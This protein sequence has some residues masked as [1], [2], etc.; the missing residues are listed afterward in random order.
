MAFVFTLCSIFAPLCSMNS[1]SSLAI[2]VNVP[3]RFTL[4]PQEEGETFPITKLL[5]FSVEN[6]LKTEE[7]KNIQEFLLSQQW[8]VI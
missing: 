7:Y 3:H 6:K 1:H 5:Q 2:S 8:A 4:M